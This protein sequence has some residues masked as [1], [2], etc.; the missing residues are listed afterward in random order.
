MLAHLYQDPEDAKWPWHGPTRIPPP[1][2]RDQQAPALTDAQLFGHTCYDNLP[3]DKEV[4]TFLK[5]TS[6]TPDLDTEQAFFLGGER[7]LTTR[8]T[9]G[10]IDPT[11]WERLFKRAVPT[12]LFPELRKPTGGEQ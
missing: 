6:W 11:L 10:G 7:T 5:E 8:L 1:F 9:A 3:T 4:E 2:P 12:N